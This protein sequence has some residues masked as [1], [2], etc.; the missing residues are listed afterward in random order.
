MSDVD[1]VTSDPQ[2]LPPSVEVIAEAGAVGAAVRL[3]Q[4]RGELHASALAL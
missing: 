2:E 4:R 1:R 3:G